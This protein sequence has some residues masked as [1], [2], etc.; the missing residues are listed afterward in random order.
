[1]IERSPYTAF[2]VIGKRLVLVPL[3]R[4][5][6]VHNNVLVLSGSSLLLWERL[7]Q[8]QSVDSLVQEL[9][10]EYAVD[11]ERA[12][13]DVEGFLNRLLEWKAVR[14]AEASPSA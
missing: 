9:Q 3:D 7:E 5:D 1:M 12:R 10:R 2:H 11:A 4:M 14:R 13:A 6:E 8:P